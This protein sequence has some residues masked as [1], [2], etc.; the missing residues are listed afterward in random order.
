MDVNPYEPPRPPLPDTLRAKFAKRLLFFRDQPMSIALFF[1]GRG[2]VIALT[3]VFP[4]SVAGIT[5]CALDQTLSGDVC[6][7]R[8]VHRES[9]RRN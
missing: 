3:G 9:Y 5:L 1:H 4:A 2:I 8:H 6:P 7:D